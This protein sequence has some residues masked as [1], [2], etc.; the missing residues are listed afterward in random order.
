MGEEKIGI[1]Y[2]NR[3]VMVN[4]DVIM[5]GELKAHEIAVYVVLCAFASNGSRSC[6]PSYTTI[7]AKAGCSRSTVIRT[8]ASLEERGFIEKINQIG[9]DGNHKSNMYIIRTG[10]KQADE[11]VKTEQNKQELEAVSEE[12]HPG[13]TD[14]SAEAPRE[15]VV[16]QGNQLTDPQTSIVVSERNGGSV[17]ESH[18]LYVINY[19]KKEEEGEEEEKELKQKIEYEYFCTEMP[20]RIGFIDTL[21]EIMLLIKQD[22]RREQLR[23]LDTVDSCVV[24]DFMDEYKEKPISH[25]HNYSAWL[26]TVFLEYLRKRE[27]FKKNFW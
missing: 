19:N 4:Y 6:Y 12:D 18:E 7:A 9:E 1:R 22:G 13:I 14:A 24:L 17:T 21:I 26:K 20:E 27:A 16:S 23:L 25:V 3:F 5:N 11:P 2:E 10:I 15:G 8:I